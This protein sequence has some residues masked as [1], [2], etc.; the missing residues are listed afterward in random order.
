MGKETEGMREQGRRKE[1]Q[2]EGRRKKVREKETERQIEK[3]FS[4]SL[5]SEA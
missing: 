5:D 4:G 3:T 2:E 1:R